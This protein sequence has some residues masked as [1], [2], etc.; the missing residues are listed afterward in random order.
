M[1]AFQPNFS[2]IANKLLEEVAFCNL[3]LSY[4]LNSGNNFNLTDREISSFCYECTSEALL[5]LMLDHDIEQSL[6]KRSEGYRKIKILSVFF[7]LITERLI[8]KSSCLYKNE[9]VCCKPWRRSFF[10][11]WS[12]SE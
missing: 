9:P 11:D 7:T 8:F 10:C 4:H 3:Q 2:T 12:F 5:Q 6:C 1:Q